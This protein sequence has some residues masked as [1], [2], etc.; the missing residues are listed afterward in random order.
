MQKYCADN[1]YPHEDKIYNF[2]KGYNSNDILKLNKG[3]VGGPYKN[4]YGYLLVYV[5]DKRKSEPLPFDEVKEEIKN[6]LSKKRFSEY[7]D[8]IIKRSKNENPVSIINS[9]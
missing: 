3:E 4:I 1:P 5:K 6:L 9:N 7:I 8:E 2:S